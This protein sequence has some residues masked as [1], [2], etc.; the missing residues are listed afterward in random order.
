M[1]TTNRSNNSDLAAELFGASTER[2]AFEQTARERT[3]EP[4]TAG[5]LT[6]TTWT[7]PILITVTICSPC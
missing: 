4:Q 1:N 5:A 3:D 6:L 7:I 2:E